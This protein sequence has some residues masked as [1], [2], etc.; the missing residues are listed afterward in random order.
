M[1]HY[2]YLMIMVII[3]KITII[4]FNYPSL[5]QGQFLIGVKNTLVRVLAYTSVNA[6]VYQHKILLNNC[7]IVESFFTRWYKFVLHKKVFKRLIQFC[8]SLL[9]SCI[10]LYQPVSTMVVDTV[11]S[12]W[13]HLIHF[14]PNALY[15]LLTNK[16]G[17]CIRINLSTSTYGIRIICHKK[18]LKQS[19]SVLIRIKTNQAKF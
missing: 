19:M 8:I 15:Y 6:L 2:H 9:S 12:K 3:R 10:I 1:V 5:I 17:K 18:Q 4:F 16:W 14:S 7:I 11:V 13:I